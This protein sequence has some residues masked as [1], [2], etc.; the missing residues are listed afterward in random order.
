MYL[1]PS[2]DG[3]NKLIHLSL[4]QILTSA[5]THEDLHAILYKLEGKKVCNALDIIAGTISKSLFFVDGD[6][7][8]I[9][10]LF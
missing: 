4:E 9:K 2:F 7:K 10:K 5:I 6:W 3:W 8:W 1:N